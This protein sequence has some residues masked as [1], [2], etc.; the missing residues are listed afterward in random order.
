MSLEPATITEGLAG[1]AAMVVSL[2]GPLSL[3][4]SALAAASGARIGAVFG[5]GAAPTGRMRMV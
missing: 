4:A 2:C 5:T 1:E 3:L